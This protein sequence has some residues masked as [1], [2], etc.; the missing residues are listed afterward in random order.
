MAILWML[1]WDGITPEQ[2]DQL[3]QE[4]NWEGDIPDGLRFHVAAFSEKGLVVSEVWESADHV[5]PFIDGRL[6]PA[7]E[8]L[9]IR[10]MPRVDLYPAHA[11]FEPA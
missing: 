9:G 2:Y 6:L 11:V 3:R 10:S 4:V 8:A 1:E 5:Q 7:V